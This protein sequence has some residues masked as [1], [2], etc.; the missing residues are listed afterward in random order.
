MKFDLKKI[1]CDSKK[2]KFIL[3]RLWDM[4]TN[5]FKWLIH[6][7]SPRPKPYFAISWSL[8]ILPNE[9][10]ALCTQA[11]GCAFLQVNVGK[12]LKTLIADNPAYSRWTSYKPYVTVTRMCGVPIPIMSWRYTKNFYGKYLLKNYDND[13]YYCFAKLLTCD[14]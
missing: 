3:K 1:K 6:T 11:K 13:D 4:L 7:S 2:I 8:T 9:F 12:E 10:Y 5:Y 14:A